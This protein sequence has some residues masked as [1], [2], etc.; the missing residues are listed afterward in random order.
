MPST[1]LNR[2]YLKMPSMPFCDASSSK[3]YLLCPAEAL[4]MLAFPKRFQL[5]QVLPSGN[6]ACATTTHTEAD[7][8]KEKNGLEGK[9]FCRWLRTFNL[10]DVD[11]KFNLRTLVWN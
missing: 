5:L 10:R 1:S 2:I 9:D 8:G 4:G 11:V 7:G 6:P 3:A